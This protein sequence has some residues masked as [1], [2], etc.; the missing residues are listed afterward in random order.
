MS[1]IRKKA[2]AAVVVFAVSLLAAGVSR[3]ATI[4]FGLDTEFSCIAPA[5]GTTPWVTATFDD[6]FGGANTVRLTMSAPNLTGG[7]DG[8]D[9]NAFYFNFDPLLDPRFLA[10]TAV[11]NSDSIPDT[12]ARAPDNFMADGDGF[13]DILFEF[14]PPATSSPTERFTGGETVIYDLTY[15][16]AISASSF[17]YFSVMGAGAGAFKAAA[18]IQRTGGGLDS[19]WVGVVPEPGTAALLALG[20]TG[21][22]LRRRRA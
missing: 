11:D 15:V 21:L 12:I 2:L 18:H 20:L 22:G 5:S 16:S 6:S 7:A 1:W 19:G 17:D 8:E 13:F 10:F 3:A 9:I 4:S 14:P